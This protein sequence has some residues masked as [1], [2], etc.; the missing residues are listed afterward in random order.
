MERILFQYVLENNSGEEKFVQ[1]NRNDEDGLK[2]YDICEMFLDFMESVGFS[3][4]NIFRYFNE[5]NT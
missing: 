4:D 5:E 3:E 2:D 1:C